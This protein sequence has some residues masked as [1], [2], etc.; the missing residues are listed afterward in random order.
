M[1]CW[2]LVMQYRNEEVGSEI[3]PVVIEC[4]VLTC[5]QVVDSYAHFVWPPTRR[6]LREAPAGRPVQIVNGGLCVGSGSEDRA[7]VVL[8]TCSRLAMYDA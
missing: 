1:F 7:M 4:D 5:S 8:R 3:L 2:W 6:P